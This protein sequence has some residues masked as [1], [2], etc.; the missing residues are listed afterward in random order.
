[1]RSEGH[2][3]LC[4]AEAPFV[5]RGRPYLEECYIIPPQ[6]GGNDSINNV[7]AVCPNCH[8][9]L[10]KIGTMED[11][12]KLKAIVEQHN[13]QYLYKNYVEYTLKA[14]LNQNTQNK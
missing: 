14:E 3:E 7:A 5:Y 4:G 6:E 12:Q 11:R 1:M 8:Q 9:K 13:A 10:K 2:C